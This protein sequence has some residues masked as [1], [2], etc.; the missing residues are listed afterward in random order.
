MSHEI[1]NFKIRKHEDYE[2]NTSIYIYICICICFSIGQF[3]STQRHN[4]MR[5]VSSIGSNQFDGGSIQFNRVLACRSSFPS[6][7]IKFNEFFQFDNPIQICDSA[8]CGDSSPRRAEPAANPII[9]KMPIH[10]GI[11]IYKSIKSENLKNTNQTH[12]YIYIYIHVYIY[13]CICI[14]F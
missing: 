4:S 2:L 5:R 9:P 3:S 6:S 7:S 11:K 1:Q 14:C 10:E 13:I 8:L 12:Q